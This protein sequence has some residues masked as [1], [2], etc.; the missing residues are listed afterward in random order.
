VRPFA[1]IVAYFN[2]SFGKMTNDFGQFG[3]Y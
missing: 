1:I 2:R 3:L